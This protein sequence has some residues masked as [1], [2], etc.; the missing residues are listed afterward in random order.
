MPRDLDH[1][2]LAALDRADAGGV[3]DAIEAGADP[4]ASRDDATHALEIAA[5]ADWAAI[6]SPVVDGAI[7]PKAAGETAK[8][9]L[10][11]LA[12][13][14]AGRGS[15]AERRQGGREGGPG[16]IEGGTRVGRRRRRARR[17]QADPFRRATQSQI[18][19]RG[20]RMRCATTAHDSRSGSARNSAGWR[21]RQ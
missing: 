4:D 16:G 21:L 20:W 8:Q 17:A 9:V 18:A 5:R 1:A 11:R 7:D 2:L 15:S 12:R 13:Q 6:P 14:A 3:R 19:A 10:E